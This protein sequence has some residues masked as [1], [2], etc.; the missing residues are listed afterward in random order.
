MN[1][2]RPLRLESGFYE[3]SDSLRFIHDEA[4]YRMVAP[5]ALLF[6]I[7]ARVSA[8][9]PP[10]W[11]LPAFVGNS[12]PPSLCV[13][14]VGK[15]GTGK[16]AANNTA[17]ELL[18]ISNPE[19]R[20]DFSL[21]TGQGL[22]EAY[23]RPTK[24][25]EEGYEDGLKVQRFLGCHFEVD[26]GSSM[27]ALANKK[28]DI[29]LD[30]IRSLWSGSP[31]GQTNASTSTSRYLPANSAA[32]GLVVG[33]QPEVAATFVTVGAGLGTPQRFLWANAVS[34]EQTDFPPE[35]RG[36]LRV[37][38][39][40]HTQTRQVFAFDE[41]IAIEVRRR[42]AAV[43]RGEIEIDPLE[44]H[45][46]LKRMKVAACLA[47]LEGE[48]FIDPQR[49]LLA[50]MITEVSTNVLHDIQE[51]GQRAEQ[52]RREERSDQKAES[53]VRVQEKTREACAKSGALAMA[54]KLKK[55]ITPLPPA[56]LYS[57]TSPDDRKRATR[58][59]MI[60]VLLREQ[61]AEEIPRTNKQ[62][63]YKTGKIAP[64]EK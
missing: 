63:L 5:D 64:P 13:A 43:Q 41:S 12:T 4:L 23:L 34:P 52:A 38:I 59:E 22:I 10:S 62:P 61:W 45:D 28:E 51:Q 19:Y 37:E 2:D 54:R 57:A 53:D 56:V 42:R 9:I 44:A 6:S 8:S 32:F 33:F 14:V 11:V 50:G 24:K 18:N 48:I 39:L 55:E 15:S 7:L 49:W 58:E 3:F 60:E 16:S 35:A 31:V 25:H 17:R 1:S 40:P 46:L 26:E 20:F 36:Q 30:T 27:V 47:R 29:T 21:G